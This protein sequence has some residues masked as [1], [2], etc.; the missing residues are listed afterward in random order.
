MITVKA[1]VQFAVI[2]PGGF[3]ILS[4]IENLARSLE[5]V[6]T[7]TSGTDGIHSGAA[8]PHHWGGAYDIRSHDLPD[9]SAFL[10]DLQLALGTD[11]FYAF[12]E[13]EGTPTEH[14]HVQVRKGVT[15]T[16]TTT[17]PVSSD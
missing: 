10:Q 1:G 12:L 17:P 5:L 14:V 7:I 3:R 8:D 15:Y 6:V 16:E 13:D 11:Q 9:A 4:A 2:S